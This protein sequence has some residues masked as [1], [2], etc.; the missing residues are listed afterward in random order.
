MKKLGF[1]YNPG[2]ANS[3]SLIKELEQICPKYGLELVKQVASKTGDVAQSMAAL[4]SKSDAIF[5]SND[6]TALSAIPTIVKVATTAKI[7][8]FVSDTDAVELGPIAALGPNQYEVG[9]Q[10]G[11]MVLKVLKGIDIN[12][13]PI[14]FPK[15]TELY[16]NLKSAKI[17]GI[18]IPTGLEQQATK[19]IK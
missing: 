10:T 13:I 6:S 8:V 2:E 11:R 16:L 1:L 4:V 14:E 18:V 3:I 17:F 9:K 5:I 15:K 19:I 7:P 12:K